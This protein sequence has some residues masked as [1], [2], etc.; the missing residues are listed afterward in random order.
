M[1]DKQKS[2]A[3]LLK[4]PCSECGGAVKWGTITQEFER[5]GLSVRVAGIRALVCDQCGEIYFSPEGT[6]NLVAAV[7][8]LYALA[9]ANGQQTGRLTATLNDSSNGATPA[10]EAIAQREESELVAVGVS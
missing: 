7:N 3:A 10:A 6:Q 9:R 8:S 2:I 5:E 1:K 4:A